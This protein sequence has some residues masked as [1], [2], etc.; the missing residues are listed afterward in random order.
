MS[1][2]LLV[3]TFVKFEYIFSFNNA[4]IAVYHPDIS[5]L[6]RSSFSAAP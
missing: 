6:N 4:E 5:L 1:M 3:Y 2:H